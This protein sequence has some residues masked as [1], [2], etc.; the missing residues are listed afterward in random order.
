LQE[1]YD[2]AVPERIIAG[3]KYIIGIMYPFAH[4]LIKLSAKYTKSGTGTNENGNTP[5]RDNEGL[6]CQ[7]CVVVSWLEG[8]C[9]KVKKNRYVIVAFLKH[10]FWGPIVFVE[11]IFVSTFSSHV[12]CFN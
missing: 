7:S 3:S 4:G 6:Q 12:T 1:T 8:L 5:L 10:R 9:L 2:T 11:L